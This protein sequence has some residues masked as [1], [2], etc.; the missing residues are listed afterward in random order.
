MKDKLVLKLLLSIIMRVSYHP[1]III[2]RRLG[3]HNVGWPA[4]SGWMRI[5]QIVIVGA[6]RNRPSCSSRL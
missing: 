2:R 5:A 6:P 4:G 3:K 1:L